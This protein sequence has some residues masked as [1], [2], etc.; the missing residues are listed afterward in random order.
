MNAKM[1]TLLAW[2]TAAIASSVMAQDGI[3]RIHLNSIFVYEYTL[4]DGQ[5]KLT[6][7]VPPIYGKEESESEDYL[8]RSDNVRE[9]VVE[10]VFIKNFPHTVLLYRFPNATNIVYLEDSFR[11]RDSGNT[12]KVY[13]FGTR[14]IQE[15]ETIDGEW[16]DVDYTY[17]PK[18]KNRHQMFFRIKPDNE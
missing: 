5:K 16:R 1:I 14:V 17:Y 7:E 12:A 8:F 18:Y 2:S 6:A 15:C 13:F 4:S 10:I 3:K 11:S 9:D